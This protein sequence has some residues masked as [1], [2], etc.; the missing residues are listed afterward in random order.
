M[1]RINIEDDIELR[2]EF[3]RLLPLVENDRERALG[4]L[5]LFFRL[6]QRRYA[7]GR[8]IG[9][10]ELQELRLGCMVESGWAVEIEGGYQAKGAEGQF[11]WL[12]EARK[13]SKKGGDAT[14]AKWEAKR[15]AKGEPGGIPTASPHHADATPNDSPLTLT[16][17]PTLTLKKEKPKNKTK[18]ASENGKAVSEVIAAYVN[19]YRNR[20]GP[21]ARP[22][23]DGKTVGS[24]GNLLRDH[25]PP[26]LVQLVQA[27]CQ[28]NDKWFLTKCHDFHTFVANI[29]KVSLALDT[30]RDDPTGDR[31]NWERVF[32]EGKG[33][34]A[35]PALSGGS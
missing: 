2:D 19:A 5:V 13:N 1:P 29:G 31:I 3:W 21:A 27:F 4:K 18:G 28:M 22:V 35:P 26:R 16:L 23:V 6:A 15:N 25:D 7:E 20:Y 9:L 10:A 11:E 34:D 24:I 30:G 32:D 33:E 8:P 17:S 14:R 12:V